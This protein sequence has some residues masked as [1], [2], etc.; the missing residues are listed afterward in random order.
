MVKAV[1]AFETTALPKTFPRL[2]K[3]IQT[4]LRDPIK[5]AHAWISLTGK[6]GVEEARLFAEQ[7]ADYLG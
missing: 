7:H 3:L 2:L 4:C 5:N 6:Y 1:K